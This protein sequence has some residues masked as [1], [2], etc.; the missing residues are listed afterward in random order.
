MEERAYGYFGKIDELGGTVAAVKRNYLEREV[1]DAAFTLRQEIDAYQL[2]VV[3]V[4]RFLAADEESISTLHIN[5]ALER[6]QIGRLEAS[7]ARREGAEVEGAL[8]ALHKDAAHEGRDLMESLLR[9][10]RAQASEREIA[11]S[12]QQRFG[13]CTE[14]PVF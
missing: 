5:P 8:A 3:G 11:W 10:A 12:L 9:C 1:A 4:N 2:I 13:D 14:T 6:K 7:R